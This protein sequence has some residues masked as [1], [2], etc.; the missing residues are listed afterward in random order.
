[1][2]NGYLDYIQMVLTK[3]VVI[4]RTQVENILLLSNPEPFEIEHAVNIL[5][6]QE[7]TLVDALAK[8]T[9]ASEGETLEARNSHEPSI[10]RESD[11]TRLEYLH[12]YFL[13][14]IR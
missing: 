12:G 5:K 10:G 14:S 11:D 13:A 3:A 7:E 6:I 8:I 1:S 4:N 2:P 9:S